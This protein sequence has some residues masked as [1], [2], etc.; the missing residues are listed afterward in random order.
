MFFFGL[1]NDMRADE[2]NEMNGKGGSK[3]FKSQLKRIK[4]EQEKCY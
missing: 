2:R 1:M 3:R 4:E